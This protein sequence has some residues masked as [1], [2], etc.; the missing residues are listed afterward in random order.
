MLS[1]NLTFGDIFPPSS[2]PLHS[3]TIYHFLSQ[4]CQRARPLAIK[5][6]YCHNNKP[7]L[8]HFKLFFASMYFLCKFCTI[9]HLLSL[10]KTTIQTISFSQT[11]FFSSSPRSERNSFIFCY[12]SQNFFRG[13]FHFLFIALPFFNIGLE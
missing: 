9:Y 10:H 13:A 11:K 12:C 6:V 3:Y 8:I 1:E 5:R 2:H 7:F 4:F